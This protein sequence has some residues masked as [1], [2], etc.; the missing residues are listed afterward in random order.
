MNTTNQPTTVSGPDRISRI[1]SGPVRLVTARFTRRNAF[2]L[3]M[4]SLPALAVTILLTLPGILFNT[5][6][7][8]EYFQFAQVLDQGGERWLAMGLSACCSFLCFVIPSDPTS[9]L[10]IERK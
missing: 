5:P 6:E 9:E 2:Y 4:L 7:Q 3:V 8:N 1:L 10:T